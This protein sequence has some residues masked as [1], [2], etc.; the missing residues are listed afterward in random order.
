MMIAAL[1]AVAALQ[2][3][4]PSVVECQV[5]QAVLSFAYAQAG[6]P[7][8]YVIPGRI[9]R[10]G[11]S[12]IGRKGAA[13]AIPKLAWALGVPETA[14]DELVSRVLAQEDTS[15]EP[16]CDEPL[17]PI[18]TN[19]FS[20]PTLTSDGR[21][22]LVEFQRGLDAPYW[23]RVEVCLAYRPAQTWTASCVIAFER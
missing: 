11:P 17:K 1:M 8:A 12:K 20:R 3:L 21:L 14:A 7:P 15:W 23:D 5:V 16:L 9:V 18:L 10:S 2:D 4:R 6:T 19:A 13:S 22:A